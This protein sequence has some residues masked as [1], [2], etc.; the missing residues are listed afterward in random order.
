MKTIRK[1]WAVPQG[2]AIIAIITLCALIVVGTVAYTLTNVYQARH[3][4]QAKQMT[5]EQL[6][7]IPAPRKHPETGQPLLPVA[8][9]AE[10]PSGE[11][12][13]SITINTADGKEYTAPIDS[14]CLTDGKGNCDEN[15]GT[16]HPP[17][18]V[19]R[20]GWW[21][22]SAHPGD[23]DNG[24]IVLAGHVDYG[25]QTGFAAIVQTIKEGDMITLTTSEGHRH[26][27][28]ASGSSQLVTKN[29][30][31]AEYVAATAQTI[32]K[33]DGQDFVTLVS[34]GGDFVGGTLGYAS[35]EIITAYPME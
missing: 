33:K 5:A 13:V 11:D 7:Q 15:S 17:T 18:D 4:G 24:S 28:R 27:Y 10:R 14:M 6:N 9:K 16:F 20:I 35:N 26:R 3:N 30:P 21:N 19:A 1:L 25:G 12:P 34:C 31:E 23:K 29:T 22:K 2:K 8:P 32:N